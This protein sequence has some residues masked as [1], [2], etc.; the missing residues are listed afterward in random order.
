MSNFNLD[1]TAGPTEVAVIDFPCNT[2]TKQYV[3]RYVLGLTPQLDEPTS[4]SLPF[5]KHGNQ[6]LYLITDCTPYDHV[7]L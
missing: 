5:W 3:I 6:P 1:L 2:T 4:I 7:L